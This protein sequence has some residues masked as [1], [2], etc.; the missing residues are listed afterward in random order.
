MAMTC[1]VTVIRWSETSLEATEFSI[2]AVKL[3]PPDT[4]SGEFTL[5]LAADAVDRRQ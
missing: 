2:Y 4:G 3:R 1:S 5:T